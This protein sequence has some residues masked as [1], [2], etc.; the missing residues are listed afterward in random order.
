MYRKPVI[1]HKTPIR[2]DKMCSTLCT[3]FTAK[4]KVET[5]AYEVEVTMLGKAYRS[6]VDSIYKDCLVVLESL[7]YENGEKWYRKQRRALK[8]LHQKW[9][10]AIVGED[11]LTRKKRRGVEKKNDWLRRQ[12]EIKKHM[13]TNEVESHRMVS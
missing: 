3:Y 10:N 9:S 7:S 2:F 12:E 6:C 8:S 13:L 5:P 1:L 11:P 4:N